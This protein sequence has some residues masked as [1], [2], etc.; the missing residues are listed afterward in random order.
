MRDER[1]PI[2]DHHS[3]LD[4]V[5]REIVAALQVD[6]RRSYTRLAADIGVNESVVRYR[7]Q[8]MQR[9]GIL[10]VVGIADPLKIGFD[11][12]ALVT[13][14][15]EPGRGDEVAAAIV[16]FP[17]VSYLATIAGGYDLHV[18]VVC[19]DA[20]HFHELLSTRIQ[21]V[22]GVRSTSSSLILKIHKMAYG[23]GVGGDRAPMAGP[24][25]L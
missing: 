7:V 11:M 4:R 1:S 15:V 12:M 24:D 25:S 13:I 5:D 20:T 6:G 3:G 14:S 21:R 22:D 8:R 18:E 23:W 2:D 16:E 19:R 17:E 10:Q 9:D